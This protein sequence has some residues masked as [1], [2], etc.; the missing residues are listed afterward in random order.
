[1]H[2]QTP[3]G[4]VYKRQAVN[5]SGAGTIEFLVD[6]NRDFYFLEMNTRLQ[7]EHPLSLIHIFKAKFPNTD[8]YMSFTSRTC[9]GRVEA[10]TGIAPVSYTHLDVYKRQ[11]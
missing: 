6:K 9:I 2:R 7:V 10:S 4:D 11:P 3:D 1:M 8:I 5:Y